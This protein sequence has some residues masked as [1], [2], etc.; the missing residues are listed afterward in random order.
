MN[1]KEWEVSQQARSCQEKKDMGRF[2]VPLD[3]TGSGEW[4]EWGSTKI[5]MQ[6][7]TQVWYLMLADC[8]A[9]THNRFPDMPKIEIEIEALNNDSHFSQEEWY[10]LSMNVF[11]F[12]SFMYFLGSAAWKYI[13]E[14]KKEELVES[15]LALLVF[16]IVIELKQII[17]EFIHLYFY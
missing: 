3:I 17:F 14:I 2:H 6:V 15:P 7:R 1:D 12:I 8:G 11:M 9:S 4:T 5:T 10:V 13:Q 16:A